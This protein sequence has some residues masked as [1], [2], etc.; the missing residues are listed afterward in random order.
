[1]NTRKIK[2]LMKEKNMSIYRLSK[3]TGISDSLL[4]K[5]LNGKVENPRIQ[6]VKQIAKALNVTIDEIVNMD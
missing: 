4:G 5:I 1:M 6:T 3:E 2:D